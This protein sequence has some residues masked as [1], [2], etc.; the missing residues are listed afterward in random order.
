M[1]LSAVDAVTGG[2]EYEDVFRCL[3]TGMA[4]ISAA[5]CDMLENYVIRWQI[6][7]G[8]W[9]KEADWTAD[10]DGY[11]QEISEVRRQRL[12]AVNAVRRR[13]RVLFLELS[14]GLKAGE[15]VRDKA[16]VLY[17]FTERAGVPETLKA[18]TATLYDGGQVQLAE[19]Y[20]QL[21]SI[22]CGVLDQFVEL[23]G[24]VEVDGQEFA[25]L[26][27]LVL[28]QYAVA[29]IPATLDQVKVTPI[30]RNDRH[31]VRHLFLLGANDNVLP[32]VETGAGCWTLRSG[33]FC[34]S[35]ASCCRTPRLTPSA[36][37]CRTSMRVWRS[38]RRR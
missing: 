2:F 13:V 11:G 22:F 31:T 4:G 36:R 24:D 8:M 12:E 1:V 34:S 27:R 14:E 17:R 28:S 3:K 7:G 20:S 35:G 25:R 30:T 19:E 10:P 18:Q 5:E 6:R 29:T 38:L 16:E 23:L 9:L 32:T 15:T 33:S 37:N 21:W 26:L